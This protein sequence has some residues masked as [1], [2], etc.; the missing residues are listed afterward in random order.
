MQLVCPAGSLPALKSALRQGADA[1]YVGFRDDTNARHFAGLN[2]D[3]RQLQEGLRRVHEAGRQL[4]VAVNTY[5][6]AQGWERWQRAVDQAADLGAGLGNQCRGPGPLSRT[7]RHPSRGPAPRA[8]AG[9][10]TPG[11]GR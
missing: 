7:L 1:I 3:E 11:G 2:L 5:S 6:S 9:A 8:I 10:G 4:Y